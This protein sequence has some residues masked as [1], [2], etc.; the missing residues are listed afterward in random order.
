MYDFFELE[1][2]CKQLKRKKIIKI[3]SI[4]SI[5]ILF[6]ILSFF[7][8]QYFTQSKQIHKQ[9]QHIKQ[10]K[11]TPPISKKIEH[12]TTIEKK[13]IHIHKKTLKPMIKE[14]KVNKITIKKTPMLN[15]QIDL[16]SI[17][18][19]NIT[20]KT[21]NKTNKIEKPKKIKENKK[22]EKP[23][24][25]HKNI[26]QNETI[27]FDKAIK[28]AELYYNNA[29]YQNSIKWCK[30]ASKIDNSDAKVWKLYALNLEKIGQKQKAIK[31]LKTYLEYKDSLDL[32]YLLQRL[33]K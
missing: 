23:I 33:E 25:Q 21:T 29:D 1:K 12:N 32:K 14:K 4:F 26:L 18:E 30:I 19:L 2:K 16:N 24:I 10:H 20:K 22:I 6:L 15:I 9:P 7:I 17:K 31:V 27:S 11:I 8:F 13:P 28:L 5:I 3:T